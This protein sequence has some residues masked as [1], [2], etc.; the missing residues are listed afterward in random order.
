MT[1]NSIEHEWERFAE[2]V[3]RNTKPSETQVVEMRKAFFAGAWTMV[4]ASVEI[5]AGRVSEPE[6]VA[7]LEARY[8]ECEE[9]K[10]ALMREYVEKQ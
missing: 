1:L 2:M 9:Y 8:R 5:G 7:Y 10:R 6:G 3:F 4:I